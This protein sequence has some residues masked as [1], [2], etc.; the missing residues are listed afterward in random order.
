[1]RTMTDNTETYEGWSNRETW[2]ANLWLAN[3]QGLYNETLDL[4]SVARQNAEEQGRT[5]Q[6]LL[7]DAIQELFESMFDPEEMPQTPEIANVRN[8][9]GSMWRVDWHEIA[10][11]W[12]NDYPEED[13]S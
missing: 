7:A 4:L 2:A 1:M 3:D 10:G 12:I 13:E 5:V 8:D 11:S 6:G 9:I